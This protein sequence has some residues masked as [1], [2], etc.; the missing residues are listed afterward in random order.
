MNHTRAEN[1][2]QGPGNHS[3]ALLIKGLGR[4]TKPEPSV[5]GS[6]LE[7]TVKIDIFDLRQ[8]FKRTTQPAFW[9]AALMRRKFVA[10]KGGGELRRGGFADPE[11]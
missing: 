3:L 4:P 1:K 5:S 10:A 2:R 9:P 7:G 8:R 11:H 6:D